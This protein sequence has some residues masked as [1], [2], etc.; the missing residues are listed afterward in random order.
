MQEVSDVLDE[1]ALLKNLSTADGQFLMP[2]D[3]KN[4]ITLEKKT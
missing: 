2:R 4:I 1:K 3:M